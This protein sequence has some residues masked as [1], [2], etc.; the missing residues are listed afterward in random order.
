MPP[1]NVLI[2]P[3][4]GNC[5][6]RCNYCFYT[7]EINN[8][9]VKSYGI[10]TTDTL[11]A[12]V[13]KVL[14]YAE[15]ECT[16][17][18]Q[19]GEPTLAG[20]PFFQHLIEIQNKYNYNKVKIHN[21]I[22][23]NGYLIDNHWAEFFAKN[24]FLVGL[25][26]DGTKEIHDRERIDASGKGTYSKIM[27]TIQLFQ[28]HNVEFNILTV[29]TAHTAKNINKI[30]NFYKRNN[31]NH[32]QYIPCLD[33]LGEERGQYSYSLTPQLYSQF[34]KDLFDLWYLD[35][36][37][38]N[39]VYNRYFE[40]ILLMLTGRP[41]ESCGMSGVCNKQYTIEADGSVYPCDFYVLD[42]WRLGN[43]VT[44]SIEDID[45]AR[46]E[47]RFIETSKSIHEDCRGCKWLQLCRGGCRR[48]RMQLEEGLDKNYFCKAFYEFF[49]YSYPRFMELIKQYKL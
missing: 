46:D 32:H 49:E 3:A 20:L 8:R 4:S 24:R 48:D 1:I 36:S 11:E 22:Q 30:Y 42:E 41:P 29:V 7:D 31:L 2:K 40:N 17:A 43:L 12:I 45:K 35:V 28:N 16:I 23:T 25:S 5:N 27:R 19:G 34:L 47:N 15:G 33:P 37:K 13:K 14:D 9:K 39:M 18:F 6:M 10:M 44:Q 38:G 21:A 26:L